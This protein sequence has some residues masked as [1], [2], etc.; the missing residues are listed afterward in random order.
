MKKII[1][2]FLFF[3]SANQIYSQ[4][5]Y[6]DNDC[7]GYP[8]YRYYDYNFSNCSATAYS[9]NDFDCDDYDPNVNAP[10]VFFLDSDGDGLGDANNPSPDLYCYP[11]YQY[12][13][14]NTDWDATAHK[15]KDKPLQRANERSVSYKV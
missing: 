15:A 9:S 3:I 11:P 12:V 7:D 4:D 14:D 10:R 8:S 5:Q 1:F 6:E 2:L 13:L